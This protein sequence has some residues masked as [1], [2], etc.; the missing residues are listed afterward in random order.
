[1]ALPV[2]ITPEGS[3]GV[4]PEQEYY[5]Y[6]LDAYDPSAGTLVYSRQ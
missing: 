4:I 1:M 6:Q 5:E 3:I 2:W